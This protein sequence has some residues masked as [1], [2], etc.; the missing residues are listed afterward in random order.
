MQIN[1]WDILAKNTFNSQKNEE[2]IDPRA[3]DNILLA[4]P[5]I[6]KTLSKYFP[7]SKNVNILDFGCGTGGFCMKLAHLGFTVTGID[8]SSGMINAAKQ[9]SSSNITY[10]HGGQEKLNQEEIYNAIV[11]IMTFPF[12]ENIEETFEIFNNSIKKNGLIILAAFNPEW[13]KTC[14]QKNVFFANFD[15][16]KNPRRGWKTFENFKIPVYIRSEEEYCNIAKSLAMSKILELK[17]QF[18]KEFI[19]K[20]PDYQ[21]NNVPEYIILGFKKEY[22]TK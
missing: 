12:I 9:I 21:P 10:I 16:P 22:S 6:L 18:T 5:P 4:W 20:Y 8:P 3:A 17:P 14:L 19:E 2:H 1:P 11:S 15:S 7:D 13:V